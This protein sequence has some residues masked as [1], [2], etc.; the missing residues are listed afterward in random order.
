VIPEVAFGNADMLGSN[1]DIRITHEFQRERAS[2]MD[3]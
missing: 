1:V 2:F 3:I